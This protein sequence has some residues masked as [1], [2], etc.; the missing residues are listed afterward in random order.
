MKVMIMNYDLIKIIFR[1]G[2]VWYHAVVRPMYAFDDIDVQCGNY[3]NKL[4]LT[5]DLLP[6]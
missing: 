5:T 4:L 1:L 3:F 6:D 2:L